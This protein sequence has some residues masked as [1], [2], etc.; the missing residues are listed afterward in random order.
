MRV[1][2]LTRILSQIYGLLQIACT[3]TDDRFGCMKNRVKRLVKQQERIRQF[4]FLVIPGKYLFTQCT[5]I[6]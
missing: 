5:V 2:K 6:T 3:M 1:V 4:F